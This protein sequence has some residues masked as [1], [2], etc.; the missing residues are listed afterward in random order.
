MGEVVS[1]RAETYSV[2]F[3]QWFTSGVSFMR[4]FPTICSHIC[5]V[6][7]VSCHSSRMISGQMLL[8]MFLCV[9][10]GE[11]A[12]RKNL[13]QRTQRNTE[14]TQHDLDF[15]DYSMIESRHT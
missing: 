3:H 14:K 4:I 12:V 1:P 10:C 15:D 9:L 13:P 8:G 2:T 6:A 7:R 11:Y 5:T